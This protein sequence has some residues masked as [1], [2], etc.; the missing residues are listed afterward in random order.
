MRLQRSPPRS[1]LWRG[2]EVDRQW[3]VGGDHGP[4]VTT[5]RDVPALGEELPLPLHHRRP[6]LWIGGY[7]RRGLRHLGRSNQAGDVSVA[8][9]D[10]L[11]V[12]V[13]LGRVGYLTDPRMVVRVRPL[14]EDDQGDAAIHRAGVEVGEAE[15]AGDRS[16]DG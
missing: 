8:D 12:E 11:A 9:Q 13:D 6:N 10:P 2:G 3:G 15:G 1:F 4:R 5:L 14:L 16:G 7:V